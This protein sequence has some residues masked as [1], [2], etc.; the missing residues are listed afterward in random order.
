[1][2]ARSSARSRRCPRSARHHLVEAA[3]VGLDQLGWSGNGR[4]ARRHLGEGAPSSCRS[5]QCCVQ[6]VA[7]KCSIAFSSPAKSCGE[8][9]RVP[10]DEDTAEVEIA[11]V[12]AG[13]E[14]LSSQLVVGS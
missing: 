8:V 12:R 2:R 7:R 14:V 3:P 10:V 1:V 4:S 9:A 13:M 5:F 6:I 11:I